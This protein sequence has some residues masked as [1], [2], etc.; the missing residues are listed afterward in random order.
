ML[1]MLNKP[2]TTI[3]MIRIK[4]EPN[5]FTAIFMSF[6]TFI[7]LLLRIS[8]CLPY[9]LHNYIYFIRMICDSQVKMLKIEKKSLN[10]YSSDPAYGI[11]RMRKSFSALAES[12]KLS[13]KPHFIN[14]VFDWFS[15]FPPTQKTLSHSF[16]KA[17]AGSEL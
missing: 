16:A 17:L 9:V 13:Q 2:M 6:I 12:V 8:V 1:L 4:N 3:A 7:C 10:C 11:E 5:S 14:G 15:D